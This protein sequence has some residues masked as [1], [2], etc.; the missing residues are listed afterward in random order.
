MADN[1]QLEAF[2]AEEARGQEPAPAPAPAPRSRARAAAG[3]R[4]GQARATPKADAKPEPAEDDDAPPR[5]AGGGRGYR[6]LPCAMRTSARR[7]QDWKERAVRAETERQDLQRR[8]EEAKRPPRSRSSQ[9]PQHQPPQDIPN[10]ATDPA[11]I[12][13]VDDAAAGDTGSQR[14]AQS[15]RDAGARAARRRKGRCADYR[16]PAGCA[17]PIHRCRTSSTSRRHPYAWAVKQLEILRAQREI[18]DDPAAY[19]ERILAEGRAKWEADHAGAGAAAG[20]QHAA[21][22]ALARHRAQR[23]RAL[24]GRLV[25]PAQ[26]R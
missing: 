21:D 14:T 13:P 11:G 7:A 1:A 23:R 2:L 15:K 6:R 10:P 12:S 19:R 8:L 18:G 25:R 4:A 22:G 16:V 20:R 17:P 9:Q 5:Q 26:R 24:A 3:T